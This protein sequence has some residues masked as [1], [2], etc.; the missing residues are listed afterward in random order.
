[1]GEKTEIAWTH[2]TFNCWRGCVKVSEGCANCYAN[3][4]SH[5]MGEDFWGKD[6]PRKFYGEKH[7]NEP[8]KW[9]RKAFEAGVM[10]RVFCG[11]M[12]D[13]ME[14]R[15]DL[16]NERKRLF[17]LIEKTNNL[18]WLLLTKRPE[19]FLK[20]LPQ[21]WIKTPRENVWLMTTIENEKNMWRAKELAKVPAVVKGISME[22]LLSEVS[23]KNVDPSI[24]WFIVG[25]ESGPRMFDI[26]WARKIKKECE[27]RGNSFFMK[28][29][30]SHPVGMKLESYKGDDP[31]EWPKDIRVRDFPA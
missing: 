27:E 4:F 8:L 13:C 28:Q 11:S 12:C 21:E 14:D 23:I 1:M 24:T 19:N 17:T 9:N 31:E 7:W 25:G 18:I 6:K 10:N 2:H 15:P 26:A 29:M 16:L 5:R 3:A 30:G 22:P 20:F